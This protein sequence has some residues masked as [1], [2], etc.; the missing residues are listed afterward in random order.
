MGAGE[1]R[2][3]PLTAWDGWAALILSACSSSSYTDS[4]VPFPDGLGNF[5]GGSRP[6]VGSAKTLRCEP[7]GGYALPPL[8][9]L[10]LLLGSPFLFC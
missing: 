10:A 8:Q 1:L 2:I 7:C 3:A 9:G 4:E 5:G 6:S